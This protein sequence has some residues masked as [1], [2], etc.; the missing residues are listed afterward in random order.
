MDQLGEHVDPARWFVLDDRMHVLAYGN[1][2]YP[3]PRSL[4]RIADPLS[5]GL[6]QKPLSRV[7]KSKSPARE[8]LLNRG[9]RYVASAAPI[10]APDESVVGMVA[11]VASDRAPLSQ[12]PPLVGGWEWVIGP[13][14]E[15]HWRPELCRLYGLPGQDEPLALAPQDWLKLV[16]PT[17]YPAL[18]E[19]WDQ[20][21]E[22]G[23]DD[24]LQLHSIQIRRRDTGEQRTLRFAGRVRFENGRPVRFTGFSH[25]VTS[26]SMAAGTTSP[27]QAFLSAV[28]S[29]AQSVIL[30]VDVRLGVILWSSRNDV[31]DPGSTALLSLVAPEDLRRIETELASWRQLEEG[32]SA[33]TVATVRSGSGEW[34]QVQVRIAPFVRDVG[35]QIEQLVL[36]ADVPN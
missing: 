13:P 32:A 2:Q 26:L 35:G 34:Q 5:V 22:A 24:T 19:F 1:H 25:D 6:L 15:T 31:L 16:R 29:A 20:R 17:D 18:Q 11:A 3:T 36:V 27:E 8:V 12:E 4:R 21:V 10:L 28:L 9:R 14:R 30:V 33:T 7:L 23:V